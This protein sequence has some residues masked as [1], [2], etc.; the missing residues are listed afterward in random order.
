MKYVVSKHLALEDFSPV[1][2]RPKIPDWHAV[3]TPRMHGLYWTKLFCYPENADCS[4]ETSASRKNR[5]K[6]LKSLRRNAIP[7]TQR[8]LFLHCCINCKG[9]C[10]SKSTFK[11]GDMQVMGKWS[12]PVASFALYMARLS[13]SSHGHMPWDRTHTVWDEVR[14]WR[15]SVTPVHLPASTASIFRARRC[16]FVRNVNIRLTDYTVSKY[17][18]QVR[19]NH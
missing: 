1:Y 13:S 19:E 7:A 6:S 16:I 4:A 10:V 11:Y 3:S 18:T 12:W 5:L 2:G 15:K 17:Q 8:S 14:V 9:Y